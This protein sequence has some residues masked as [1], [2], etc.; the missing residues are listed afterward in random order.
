MYS[1]D[2]GHC[3]VIVTNVGMVEIN[4]SFHCHIATLC[5]LK[6][7][8][9]GHIVHAGFLS[10]WAPPLGMRDIQAARASFTEHTQGEETEKEG[11]RRQKVTCDLKG[12]HSFEERRPV[13]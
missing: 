3:D 8:E 6:P 12:Y 13:N 10:I 1:L 11:S 4:A 5:L 9:K 2:G 7:G